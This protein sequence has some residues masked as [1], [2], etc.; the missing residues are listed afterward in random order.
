VTV[1]ITKNY[2]KFKKYEMQAKIPAFEV[3]QTSLLKKDVLVCVIFLFYPTTKLRTR[4]ASPKRETEH[5]LLPTHIPHTHTRARA[6]TLVLNINIYIMRAWCFTCANSVCSAF[7][8]ACLPKSLCL[9]YLSL[10]AFD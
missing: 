2:L 9:L 4:E 3:P 5:L 1:C 8:K 10:P 7:E 6:H